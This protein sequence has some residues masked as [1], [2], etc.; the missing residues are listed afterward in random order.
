MKP[1][2][3][4]VV[5]FNCTATIREPKDHEPHDEECGDTYTLK[6]Y[7]GKW[8]IVLPATQRFNTML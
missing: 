1:D 6:N 4:A 8:Y 5:R 7:D 3:E 2:K